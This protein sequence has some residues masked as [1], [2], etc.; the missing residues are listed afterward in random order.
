[1]K[2]AGKLDDRERARLRQQASTWLRADLASWRKHLA[3]AEVKLRPVV[4]KTMQHWLAD[5]DFAGVRDPEA[6]GKLPEAERQ[7]WRKL[8]ADVQDLWTRTA[9]DSPKKEK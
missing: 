3:A 9:G 5:T 1:G 6:L 8:W 7:D 4:R 2:D